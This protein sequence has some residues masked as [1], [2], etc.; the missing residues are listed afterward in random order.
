[1]AWFGNPPAAP[2]KMRQWRGTLLFLNQ[3]HYPQ[4]GC[5]SILSPPGQTSSTALVADYIPPSSAEGP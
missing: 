3:M 5:W 2:A 1:M 4:Q